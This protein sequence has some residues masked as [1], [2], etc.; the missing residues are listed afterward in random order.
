MGVEVAG[1]NFQVLCH[2]R[3]CGALVLYL[4]RSSR[5]SLSRAPFKDSRPAG[6]LMNSAERRK[7]T[8]A[9]TIA[10]SVHKHPGF[11]NLEKRD[12]YELLLTAVG[13]VANR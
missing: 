12:A 8:W 13:V 2:V 9:P 4:S 11:K 1:Q 6:R 10:G 7:C 3:E 5:A